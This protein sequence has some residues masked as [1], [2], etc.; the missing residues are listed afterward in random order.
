MVESVTI[1]TVDDAIKFPIKS[2]VK[3]SRRKAL[4]DPADLLYFGTTEGVFAGVRWTFDQDS[5]VLSMGGQSWEIV[6]VPNIRG[7]RGAR[8]Y[9]KVGR[10][11]F[12]C[13]LI[14]NGRVGTRADLKYKSQDFLTP[15]ERREWKKTKA[16]RMTDELR[17]LKDEWRDSASY[18]IKKKA[19][20]DST[21][22]SGGSSS[23][24]PEALQAAGRGTSRP[25]K[26]TGRQA[27]TNAGLAN[28]P[29]H[30]R[31]NGE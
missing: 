1:P 3:T 2:L 10:K 17:P 28:R 26:S 11:L 5:M 25:G 13:L 29:S 24:R 9:V 18:G 14:L 4:G 21:R 30:R 20:S 7:T 27:N 6:V 19:R 23:R 15:H 12:T 31:R 22:R 8:A 16:D